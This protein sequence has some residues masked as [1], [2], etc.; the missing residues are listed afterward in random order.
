MQRPKKM[1]IPAGLEPR[2][3]RSEAP[4]PPGKNLITI[5]CFLL[6][7]GKEKNIIYYHDHAQEIQTRN[8]E[9]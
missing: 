9:K 6:V 3:A 4:M 7:A 8:K 2:I 1:L 5:I